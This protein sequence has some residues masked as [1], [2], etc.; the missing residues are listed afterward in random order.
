MEDEILEMYAKSYNHTG[1]KVEE[2]ARQLFFCY[3]RKCK[4][5][6]QQK[7]AMKMFRAFKTPLYTTD[8]CLFNCKMQFAILQEEHP[9]NDI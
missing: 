4:Y 7:L 9:I 6:L 1:G 2:L 3:G 8:R 5:D